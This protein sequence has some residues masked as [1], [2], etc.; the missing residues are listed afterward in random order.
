[1]QSLGWA[2]STGLIAASARRMCSTRSRRPRPGWLALT[3]RSD[4]GGVAEM[5]FSL[6]WH[7]QP[8]LALKA[9]RSMRR[10][11]HVLVGQG[12]RGYGD[13]FIVDTESPTPAAT[14][15]RSPLTRRDS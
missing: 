1:V 11:A 15:V 12:T 10:S 5:R 3:A 13:S 2:G 14:T 7:L 4:L 8:V 9:M 6:P